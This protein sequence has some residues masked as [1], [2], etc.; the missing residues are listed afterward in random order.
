MSKEYISKESDLNRKIIEGLEYDADFRH[1]TDNPVKVNASADYEFIN[2]N[3]NTICFLYQNN[4]LACAFYDF[5]KKCLFYLND[6]PETSSFE[7]ADLIIEDVEPLNIVTSAKNDLKFIDFLKKK[8]RVQKVVT[9]KQ[10]PS[11]L[12][13]SDSE[14]DQEKSEHE[15][16]VKRLEATNFYVN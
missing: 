13:G 12:E 16:P 8:C 10:K 2:N 15:D 4:K 5:N 3:C 7:L 9:E 11:A 1:S 14:G 6:L